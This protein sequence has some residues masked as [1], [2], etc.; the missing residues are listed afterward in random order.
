MSI[1]TVTAKHAEFAPYVAAK[2]FTAAE[3]HAAERITD[4]V[5]RH[6]GL[7]AS[8]LDYLSV[9]VAVWAP[10]NGHVCIDIPNVARQV[11]DELGSAG[12]DV[13]LEAQRDLPWHDPSDWLDHLRSSP[14]VSIP[15]PEAMDIVDFEKPLVLF[16]DR[17]YLTRQWV[18][19]GEAA[20]ALRER[21]TASPLPLAPEAELWISEVFENGPDDLQAEAVR[22]ALGHNTSVLLG[23]PGTGKTYTIAGLLHALYSEQAA[24][25]PDQPLRVAIAAP[26]GKAAKQV[27]KSIM[28]SLKS[29]KFPQSHATL[30]E[31]V[32]DNSST[33]HRLLGWQPGNRGRFVHHRQNHLPYDVVVIDETSMVSLPLMARLLE[34]LSP[35][36]RL[37]LV[38]DPQQLKSVEAGA[39]L[40]DVA[41]LHADGTYPITKLVRNRRQEDEAKPDSV[42]FIGQLAEEISKAD[43]S[44]GS[45][46][47]IHAF[48]EAGHPGVE[49]LSLP[50]DKPD[51]TADAIVTQLSEYLED[52]RLAKSR[53]V[54]G[55][56]KGAIKALESIRVLCGHRKGRYGISTWNRIVADKVGVAGTRGS[57]GQPLLN[58]RNDLRTGL[59]NGD[60]GIVVATPSGRRVVFPQNIDGFE[61]TALENIEVAFATTV[62]KAQGSE[63]ATVVVI[64]PPVGSPLLRR[65]MLYTAVTRATKRL[66]VVATKDAVI[67]AMTS[68][69]NRQ[70]G[71]ADR[72]RR[73]QE[74]Q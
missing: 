68:T 31:G 5:F 35:A 60:T 19:E 6:Q 71:L 27:K 18:D 59:D 55:D 62:H 36:T 44:E 64:L 51:P 67:D 57:I 20:M 33:I 1:P 2:V 74:I 13:D 26:T 56:A 45:A 34:A 61:P 42:N 11:R 53:A 54:E 12:E 70:S 3:V 32:A 10:V 40:P 63:F 50:A 69:I 73:P 21:L 17:L 43:Y 25:C 39:V 65:E 41:T 49:F 46:E 37:V 72:I 48:L 30:I 38:G 14:L 23:G 47:S 52:Y 58:T 28:C 24:V 8:F 7:V 16:G 4:A 9:A 66:V 22:R 15:A 29:E